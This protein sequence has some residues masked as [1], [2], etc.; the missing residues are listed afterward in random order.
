MNE[1][2]EHIIAGMNAIL[3]KVG[4]VAT[5]EYLEDLLDGTALKD[6]MLEINGI[7]TGEREMFQDTIAY[8]LTSILW[9]SNSDSDEY[10]ERF[11]KKFMAAAEKEKGLSFL[12]N[13]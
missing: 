13:K 9:P 12:P 7:D 11:F 8:S 10:T 6:D 3:A 5:R 2:P 1:I 4:V